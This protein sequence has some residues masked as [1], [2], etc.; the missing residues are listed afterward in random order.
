VAVLGGY[1]VVLEVNI[2]LRWSLALVLKIKVFG[3]DP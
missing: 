1:G 2:E 3:S